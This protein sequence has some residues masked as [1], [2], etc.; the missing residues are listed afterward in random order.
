MR[1]SPSLVLPRS[2]VRVCMPSLG[3][4]RSLIGILGILNEDVASSQVAEMLTKG[5]PDLHTLV[6]GR[7]WSGSLRTGY[8]RTQLGSKGSSLPTA[9]S[10]CLFT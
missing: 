5:Y 4:I 8:S 10:S 2:T 6:P 3:N 9:M 7:R 1:K